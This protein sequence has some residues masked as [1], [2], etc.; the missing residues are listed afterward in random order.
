[1]LRIILLK[2]NFQE[3]FLVFDNKV[4]FQYFLR[5]G[6]IENYL[7]ICQWKSTKTCSTSWSLVR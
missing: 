2:T 3:Y 6:L 4:I 1:M 5:L 7:S